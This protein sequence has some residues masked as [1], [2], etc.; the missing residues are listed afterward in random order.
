M[1]TTSVRLNVPSDKH[2]QIKRLKGTL[3][4]KGTDVTIEQTYEMVVEAG[5][6]AME[7]K[8]K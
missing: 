6:A 1:G 4:S 2:K 8:L 5:A 3:I 7:Q